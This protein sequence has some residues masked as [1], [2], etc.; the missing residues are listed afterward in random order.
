MGNVTSATHSPIENFKIFDKN[1][2]SQIVTKIRQ[3]R[4]EIRAKI[5]G[6]FWKPVP[7]VEKPPVFVETTVGRVGTLE[8]FVSQQDFEI[9]QENIQ[10]YIS[11]EQKLVY[12]VCVLNVIF[13][14]LLCKFLVF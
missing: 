7:V 11:N 6:I 1:W 9:Y 5:A 13:A 12:A 3:F 8:Q 2:I 4:D 14:I 10:K